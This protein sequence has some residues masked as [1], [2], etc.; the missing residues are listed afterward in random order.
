MVIGTIKRLSKVAR[1]FNVGITV[2]VEFLHKKGF[3]IDANPNNKISDEMY[4]LLEKE[5]KGDVYL[6]KES[7]KINLKIHRGANESV[8][9]DDAKETGRR[10][11]DDDYDDDEVIIKGNSSKKIE[12]I[13]HHEPK[14][15]KPEHKVELF[16]ISRPEIE[17][18]KVIGTTDLDN[19]NAHKKKEEPVLH[20]ETPPEN[21]Q[22]TV[23][24]PKKVAE[25]PKQGA[26]VKVGRINLDLLIQKTRPKWKSRKQKEEERRDRERV[27][28][29]SFQTNDNPNNRRMYKESGP[30]FTVNKNKNDDLQIQ[31][32]IWTTFIDVQEQMLRL[33]SVP[34][35]I[36]PDSAKIVG[37]K[38]YLNANENDRTDTIIDEIAS[39]FNLSS[40]E[41]KVEEGYFLTDV[42]IAQNVK[43]EDK[44]QLFERAAANFINFL[45]LPIIDGFINKKESPINKL[46]N[47]LKQ[48]ELD[49]DFDKSSR[50][51]I[52]IND[53]IK[54]LEISNEEHTNIILPEIA[55][56]ILPISSN[57]KYYIAE[58]YPYLFKDNSEKMSVTNK[59]TTKNSYF[60][61]AIYDKLRDEIGLKLLWY[62]FIF[63]INTDAI[64]KYNPDK[65]LYELPELNKEDNSFC[66]YVNIER[67]YS[68]LS[69]LLEEEKLDFNYKYSRLNRFFNS[70]FGAQN[71]IFETIFNYSYNNEV[72][73]S[74]FLDKLL[75]TQ[76]ENISL[77]EQSTTI[78][79]DFKWKDVP[80][81]ILVSEL[82]A[83][84]PFIHFNFYN[85]HKCNIDFQIHDMSLDECEFLLREKF[86]SI[87][88]RRD[89]KK[90][91]LYFYQEYQN[92]EQ[93]FRLNQIME[94]ELNTLSSNI[95]NYGL[96]NI[97]EY[98]EKYILEVNNQSKL[99][100]Q[101]SAIKELRGSDFG[102]GK[103]YFGK[104]LRVNYPEMIFDISGNEFEKTKQL[105][106]SQI[107]SSIEPNL[108]GDLEKIYRLKNSLNNI[109]SGTNLE[110]PNLKEFIF[111]AE[112]A[113]KIDDIEFHV[114][115]QS[116][117][118]KELEYHLL[119]KKVNESQK[120][121]IIKT[122]LSEDLA[123][124]QGPPGTGKSTAI[125]EIIWQ[126][127]RKNP[128]ERILLTSETNLAVDNAIDRIVNKNHNL[129]KPIRFGEEKKL[130]MEGRQF[131]IDVMKRWV[132]NG[133]IEID[134]EDQTDEEELTI[135]KLIIINWIDNIKE[136]AVRTNDLDSNTLN[137]WL[138]ILSKPKKEIRQIF[139]DN[140]IKNC[141]VIGATCSSIGE[142]NTKNNPTSFFKSYCEIFGKINNVTNKNGVQYTDYRGKLS[143][144]T[145]IQDESSKATPAELS[146]PLVYGKKNIVIGDHR[147]L[148]PMLDKEEFK[149][150]LDFLLDRTENKD[151]RREIKKLK[152]FVLNNFNEM[153]IS[154]F[155]RLFDKIDASL[156]GIFNLQYRMHPDI[157]E[158]IK[159]FYINDGGLECGLITP[160]DLGVNDP[161]MDNSASRYHGIEIDGLISN[162]NHV[163]WIDTNTP[164]LLEGTSRIN[165]G[166][167]DAIRQV[168][169]KFRDSD[170]FNHFQSFWS[171][172][173]DQQI[174]LISFY[175][176]QIKLL[177][178][179]RNEFRNLPIRVSTVDR[180]QGMER[181][182][183]IVSMVRS[184]RIATDK[185]QKADYNVFGELGY[186]K[187]K[188]LGF[189]Q[190]PNRLNVAMSRAKRLLIIVGNSELFRQKDIYN[191]VYQTIAN[192]PNG[193]II[194]YETK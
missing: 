133:T 31:Q 87:K 91:T 121:A 95:F 140:Y 42:S 139:Y 27:R 33:R 138:E 40:S 10:V 141:N 105:F 7:E 132:Q 184:N 18:L 144:T 151:E 14:P 165:Y 61:E 177:T 8:S 192:N 59:I 108:T 136:R 191:S 64:K 79:I 9:L 52:S 161:N 190:S 49:Y 155:E 112:K 51:Q 164:E 145:V 119:N 41:I 174:G 12:P 149:L 123:L 85:N 170:S 38:L 183:I 4:L 81:E 93:G 37:E 94:S 13:H 126:H 75:H 122:L 125:A 88:T 156:K 89:D 193:R 118:F 163:I 116:D 35:S 101:A 167:I 84:Y 15:A 43:Q 77:S 71:V 153:E 154:H 117:T 65:C 68:E 169:T 48:F 29:D 142:R 137:L 63:R 147:Q 5:Y 127:I 114:H 107:I 22:K 58:N 166:E 173:E 76:F 128:K 69:D 135:Q 175:G 80:V 11:D 24:E 73:D 44:N 86:P 171:N 57:L 158:V 194:K 90:G 1:D 159:Q 19:L 82:Q 134:S 66:F 46:Q 97:P 3:A 148:P 143:F 50:L 55:T 157:N 34:I 62:K 23:V 104:L 102:I 99:E 129:V 160:V 30:R 17:P 45:P 130:E 54:L 179:L 6:Q 74:L 131:S 92:S 185:N 181:N 2:I 120:Q 146:L 124:I 150:S 180:F 106:E 28:C 83:K 78:G 20:K 25:T 47:L 36:N 115:S 109:V 172:P 111:D 70:F 100:S 187:Q 188:D 96:Y 189:A 60:S 72:Y 53:L 39:T 186:L 26:E 182:I 178:N 152:S 16:T 32:Q 162:D 56:I 67:D 21:Q 98:K 113:K 176:K 168:L 103:N 110:N